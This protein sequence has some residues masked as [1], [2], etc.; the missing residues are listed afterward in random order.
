MI[1]HNTRKGTTM[2]NEIRVENKVYT[3]KGM[4]ATACRVAVEQHTGMKASG[5]AEYI[6][7][8]RGGVMYAV[9]VA[10]AVYHVVARS[11]IKR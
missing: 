8:D 10:D 9:R 1:Q 5:D 2:N 4:R 11:I 6:G 7:F 3:I